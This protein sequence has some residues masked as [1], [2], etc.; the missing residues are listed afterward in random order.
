[1]ATIRDIAAEARLSIGTVSK[2]LNGKRKG[3]RSDV[4]RNAQRVYAIAQRLN[5]RPNAAARALVRRRSSMVGILLRNTQAH[6][7]HFLAA[8]ELILG[9][10]E[11]LQSAGY[12]TTLLRVGDIAGKDREVPRIFQEKLIDGL[13]IISGMPP[14]IVAKIETFFEQ[15]IWVESS[16]W[17]PNN[18]IRRDEVATGELVAQALLDA[19][20]R[21]LLWVGPPPVASSH[22]SVAQRLEGA[23]RT[24]HVAQVP[25]EIH[26]P[27]DPYIISEELVRGLTPRTGVIAYNSLIAQALANQA[28]RF[29]KNAGR[30]FGLVSC[31]SEADGAVTFPQL[32]RAEFDRFGMG[33]AAA[34]MFL[35]MQSG[36][37]KKRASQLVSSQWIAGTT[38]GLY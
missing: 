29:G 36:L 11:R 26:E 21:H 12:L 22:F 24:A 20:C 35:R 17:H 8:F 14:D 6:R 31:D 23:R 7:F 16:V 27:E 30:D 2:I 5:F 37:I 15:A 25:M 34:E 4:I 3:S 28:G 10:N 18:C 33:V 9:I 19:G 38:L 1:M 13:I 32:S